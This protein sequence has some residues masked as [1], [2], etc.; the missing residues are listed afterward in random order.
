MTVALRHR[1]NAHSAYRFGVITLSTFLVVA[2]IVGAIRNYSPVPFWDMWNGYLDFFMQVSD[3]NHAAWWAQHNE[4]RIFLSRLLFWMDLKFFHGS[5]VSLIVANYLLVAVGAVVFCAAVRKLTRS[6]ADRTL[7]VAAMAVVCGAAFFW[8]QENNLTWGFQS[9]FV[10]AQLLP[11]CALY[12]LGGTEDSA[13][14][15][16]GRFLLACL[17]GVAACG[18]MANGVLALPLM[19]VYAIVVGLPWNRV[20]VLVAVTGVTIIKYYAGYST[21]VGH[22]PLLAT[23]RSEPLGIVE[24]VLAYLGSPVSFIPHGPTKGL[25]MSLLAGAILVV[26]ASVLLVTAWKRRRDKRIVF[27]M[28]AFI[29]YVGATAL[30][31]ALGRISGGMEQ[32]LA[33]RYTTPALMAW[34]ALLIALLPTAIA[35]P[36]LR[37]ALL[38]AAPCILLALGAGQYAAL[39]YRDQ[40]RFQRAAGA[41][42]LAMDV[43]DE[44]IIGQIFPFTD[45]AMAIA[46]KARPR[47]LSVFGQAPFVDALQ[48]IG[49]QATPQD[50]GHCKGMIDSVTTIPGQ[51]FARVEGEVT[52]PD[53]HIDYDR[54]ALIDPDGK[55][56]GVAID[57]S[58]GDKQ[59]I[60]PSTDGQLSSRFLGY[61]RPAALDLPLTVMTSEGCSFKATAPLAAFTTTTQ[62][63]TT[64]D[65][66]VDSTALT[67]TQGFTGKD[68][69][70]SRFAGM[71][72]LG[73]RI[74]ADQDTGS[75][76]LHVRRGQHIFFRTGP[77]GGHQMLS[78][79]NVL[80]PRPMPVLRDWTRVTFDDPRLPDAFVV[81]LSDDGSGWGEWSA[82]AVSDSKTP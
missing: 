28:L 30:G 51:P 74:N 7:A 34:S 48:L 13:S 15:G 47:H 32:A 31:T 41:L 33:S 16:M 46:G 50:S 10:L 79:A 2:A 64:G 66:L 20:F 26:S 6:T 21:G 39:A 38:I 68:F 62:L 14:E 1:A 73:S 36:R 57:G 80:A 53:S 9:Q 60:S 44:S 56:A 65:S 8:S 3:G 58:P 5:G 4:H 67:A 42:A 18:S 55:I 29:A 35:R 43:R 70:D 63:P 54:L 78:I 76:S 52:R 24:F 45:W 81:T 69:D 72:V 61:V 75:V 77:T 19:C 25:G 23:L 82:I 71:R 17:L 37:R 11:M 49:T 59:H 27:A 12:V 22:P 40:M